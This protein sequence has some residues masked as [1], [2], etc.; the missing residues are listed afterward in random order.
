MV[1]TVVLGGIFTKIDKVSRSRTPFLSKLP[2]VNNF[3]RSKSSEVTT[4][5]TL[6]FLTPRIINNNHVPTY[7][8]TTMDDS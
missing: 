4:A 8:L 5:E 3:F 2:I 6:V 7:D 1:V